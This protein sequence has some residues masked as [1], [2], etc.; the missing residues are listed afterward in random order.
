[1]GRLPIDTPGHRQP[2][3]SI[4]VRPCTVVVVIRVYAICRCSS[5]YHCC[6]CSCVCSYCSCV[7]SHCCSSVIVC[8]ATDGDVAPSSCVKEGEGERSRIAHLDRVDGDND[9]GITIHLSMDGRVSRGG[10]KMQTGSATY[11]VGLPLLG[12]PLVAIR[13]RWGWSLVAVHVRLSIVVVGPRGQWA[14]IAVR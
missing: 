1:M 10:I 6:C 4:I 12:S 11:L 3:P 9:M 2:T 5:V 13:R 14:I 8:H 7:C